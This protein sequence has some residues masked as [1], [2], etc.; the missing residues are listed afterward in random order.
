MGASHALPRW[1]SAQS[2]VPCLRLSDGGLSGKLCGYHL[3]TTP[4][5]TP[6]ETIAA[7]VEGRCD[8]LAFESRLQCDANLEELL[9]RVPAPRHA[10]DASTLFH[11]LL[12]L[13]YR[14]PGEVLSAQ[15]ALTRFLADR[16]VPVRPSTQAAE[17]YRL[18][19]S[20]Q[21]KWLDVDVAFLQKLLAEAPTDATTSKT[22]KEWLRGQLLER[23]CCA[24]RPP[25]WLQSPQWPVGEHGPLVFLGQLAVKDYFHDE[26]AVYVF[27]DPATGECLSVLQVA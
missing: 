22:R 2:K 5:P 7:F 17:D 4:V 19:L 6:L 16:N 21:P 14:D 9:G 26:A 11:Y 10:H 20:A 3:R 24:H 13:D 8:A 12:A 1:R 18:L 23:F 15:D 27:H 25:H